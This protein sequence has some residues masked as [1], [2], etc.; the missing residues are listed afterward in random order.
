MRIALV[1]AIVACPTPE[2]HEKKEPKKYG[3]DCRCGGMTHFGS[4]SRLSLLRNLAFESQ[5]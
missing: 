5:L 4:S 1:V 3:N 2:Y